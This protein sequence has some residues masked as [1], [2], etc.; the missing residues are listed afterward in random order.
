MCM[1][2]VQGIMKES[3]IIISLDTQVWEGDT[4]SQDS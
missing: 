1:I 4:S 3:Y 2:A